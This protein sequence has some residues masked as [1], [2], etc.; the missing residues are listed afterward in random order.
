[1]GRRWPRPWACPGSL[2]VRP[3][4]TVLR[5]VDREVW[6]AQGG[7]WAEGLLCE[8]PPAEAEQEAMAL[9]GKTLRGSRK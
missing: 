4:Y 6:E 1:M 9:D 8:T 7:A 2:P 3:L 5:D